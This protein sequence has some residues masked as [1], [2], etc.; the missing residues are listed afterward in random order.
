M[1]QPVEAVWRYLFSG[2]RVIETLLIKVVIF[3]K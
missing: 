2:A 1:Q 3:V